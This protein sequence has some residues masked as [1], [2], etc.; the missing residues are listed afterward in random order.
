MTGQTVITWFPAGWIPYLIGLLEFAGV[1]LLLS[2]I[3]GITLQFIQVINGWKRKFY[4][5]QSIIAVKQPRPKPHQPLAKQGI[6]FAISG[7]IVLYVIV[8]LPYCLFG[9]GAY[10]LDGLLSKQKQRSEQKA[11]RLAVRDFLEDLRLYLSLYG[12]LG[13]ALDKRAARVIATERDQY[14]KFEQTFVARVQS[15]AA[16]AEP[17][18]VLQ[19][20]AV[21][22]QSRDLEQLNRALEL[23]RKSNIPYNQ[24][25]SRA[26]TTISAAIGNA[27]WVELEEAPVKQ[28]LPMLFGTMLPLLA[29]GMTPLVM[30]ILHSLGG[31]YTH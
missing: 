19:Q 6:L 27:I 1:A 25:L 9:A 26:A 14:S 10:F 23:S 13:Q 12:S 2:G 15:R 28:T 30:L 11:V 4:D 7:I 3:A 5:V 18:T 31:T 29:L 17:E 16:T 8:G 22:L 24:T 21:D 20:L